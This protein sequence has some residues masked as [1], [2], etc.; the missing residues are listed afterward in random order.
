MTGTLDKICHLRKLQ[1]VRKSR[2]Y[3]AEIWGLVEG[4]EVIDVL[5]GRMGKKV[6]KI[7]VLR[8]ESLN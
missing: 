6:L 3:G 2:F 7:D 1:T 5:E 4:W 8:T